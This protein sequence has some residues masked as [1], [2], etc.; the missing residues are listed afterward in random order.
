MNG[1]A[2]QEVPTGTAMCHR[3]QPGCPAW[4]AATG[5]GR[6]WLIAAGADWGD[7]DENVH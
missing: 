5:H 2:T 7:D 6:A 1:Q 3:R 4:Q